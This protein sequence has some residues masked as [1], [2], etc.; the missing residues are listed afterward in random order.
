MVR[1][2]DLAATGAGKV[3][4]KEGLE[5]E[6]EGISFVSTQLLSENVG[7]NGPRLANGYWHKGSSEAT[8]TIQDVNGS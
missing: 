3:A 4:A 2:L 7:G 5:H 8:N 6:D 1:I